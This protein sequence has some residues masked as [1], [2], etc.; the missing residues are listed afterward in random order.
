MF[1]ACV[2]HVSHCYGNYYSK[3]CSQFSQE[4]HQLGLLPAC[5]EVSYA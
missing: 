3:H 2:P 5:K 4:L 1:C